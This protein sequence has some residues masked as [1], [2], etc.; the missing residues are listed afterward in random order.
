[1]IKILTN[2]ILKVKSMS[3]VKKD[4][5]EKER[6]KLGVS[7]FVFD[8]KLRSCPSNFFTKVA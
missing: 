1:M 2:N 8:S 6:L 3:R 4:R 7:A 5:K